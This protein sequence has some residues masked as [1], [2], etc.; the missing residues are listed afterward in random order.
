MEIVRILPYFSRGDDDLRRSNRVEEDNDLKQKKQ[1][2]QVLISRL[3][4]LKVHLK[5]G[6]Y[7]Y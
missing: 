7:V 4:K 2:K 3:I 6:E 5:G 1:T